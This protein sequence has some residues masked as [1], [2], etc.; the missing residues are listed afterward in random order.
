MIFSSDKLTVNVKDYGVGMAQA[1]TT[2]PGLGLIAMRERAEL[3]NAALNISS[4]PNGGTTVSLM[5]PLRQEDYMSDLTEQ[6]DFGEVVSRN[7]E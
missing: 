2:R 5:M 3:L 7:H 4:V 1:K 6:E